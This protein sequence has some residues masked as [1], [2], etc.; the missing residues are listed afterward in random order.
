MKY[1]FP[2][3]SPNIPDEIQAYE[4]NEKARYGSFN[5]LSKTKLTKAISLNT[6]QEVW[7]KL[8]DIYEGNDRVKLSN[9]L[10]AK[11]RY[12]NL[13]MEGEDITS[14]MVKKYGFQEK[15]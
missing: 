5:A 13:R 3:N 7:E 14:I 2:P 6:A 15:K 9:K 11:H 8:K 10:I 1:V 12:E 4:K